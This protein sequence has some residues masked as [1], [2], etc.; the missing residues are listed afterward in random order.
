M[1]C[2]EGAVGSTVLGAK[3]CP[4]MLDDLAIVLYDYHVASISVGDADPSSLLQECC[5]LLAKFDKLALKVHKLPED[6]RQGH[7]WLASFEAARG[8]CDKAICEAGAG[9]IKNVLEKKGPDAA[10]SY[11]LTCSNLPM[12]L[13]PYGSALAQASFLESL[14]IPNSS[15][16]VVSELSKRTRAYVTLKTLSPDI[17]N[18]LFPQH[19]AKVQDYMEKVAQNITKV[20]AKLK[21]KC[22]VQWELL[23]KYRQEF[24]TL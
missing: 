18:L 2:I 12:C 5:N 22:K 13:K 15:T 19:V 24:R 1:K 6:R 10:S 4:P 9:W 20:I 16:V 21:D 23:E 17:V 14:E 7:E 3:K 8:R 11:I